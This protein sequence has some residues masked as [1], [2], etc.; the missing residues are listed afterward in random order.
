LRS[1]PKQQ[2][3]GLMN[4]SGVTESLQVLSADLAGSAFDDVNIS[5]ASF[6]NVNLAKCRMHDVNLTG[7]VISNAN[8]TGAAIS[9][10]SMEG[11][12]IDG[13]LVTELLRIYRAAMAK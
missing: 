5:G 6:E 1:P 3:S 2:W 8:L 7:L 4:I 12:T 9:R 10:A 11:M 13:I